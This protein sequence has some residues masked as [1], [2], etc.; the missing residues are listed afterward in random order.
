[1]MKAQPSL[2]QRRWSY[3]QRKSMGGAVPVKR[4]DGSVDVSRAMPAFPVSSYRITDRLGRVRFKFVEDGIWV[5]QPK[6][7]RPATKA[8]AVAY[9]LNN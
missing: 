3:Q 6:N 8:K 1:M 9:Y 5:N 2:Q 4:W 7:D